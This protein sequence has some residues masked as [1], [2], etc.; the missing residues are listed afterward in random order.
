MWG[1]GVS[2]AAAD[3]VLDGTHR[4]RRRDRPRARPL[5]RARPQ[6]ARRRP[7]RPA[8]PADGPIPALAE[9]TDRKDGHDRTTWPATR[10]GDASVGD[11]EDWGLLDE[12]TGEP[13]Q[14]RRDPLGG[15]RPRSA[16]SGS[17]RR[18][19][20]AGC[21]RPTRSIQVLVDGR[22][23]VT[24]DGGEPTEIN[25]GDV[26]VFPRGWSG[27]LGH[28]RAVRKVYVDLLSI[29][30]Q[31]STGPE[32]G[33]DHVQGKAVAEARLAIA[34]TAMR[35]GGATVGERD[36]WRRRVVATQE[37]PAGERRPGWLAVG[38]SRR[39]Q[40]AE[41]AGPWGGR[42]RAADPGRPVAGRPAS[43]SARCA[44]P[45]SFSAPGA[46]SGGGSCAC[47]RI[48]ASGPASWRCRCTV[49]RTAFGT[50]RTGPRRGRPCRAQPALVTMAGSRADPSGTG[51]QR[52][53]PMPCAPEPRRARQ[54][55]PHR[56]AGGRR[57]R[58]T[59]CTRVEVGTPSRWWTGLSKR[60]GYS[61]AARRQ[62]RPVR[63]VRGAGD[64][65]VRR[66]VTDGRE[67]E[68]PAAPA[69]G[70]RP[71]RRGRAGRVTAAG[72]A[73]RMWSTRSRA[74][75]ASDLRPAVRLSDRPSRARRPRR[76]RAR[77]PRRRRPGR[78]S[79]G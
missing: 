36:G 67:H 70:R 53:A 78:R 71:V 59:A 47:L 13:M 55:E 76:P 33:M 62:L 69:H 57:W 42:S 48:S 56:R 19:R 10:P 1:P 60:C 75:L 15:R 66:W 46:P 28:P 4:R 40:I 37:P 73:G 27:H 52:A 8:V 65:H 6:P 41:V 31:W 49:V 51:R 43:A 18:A 5:R 39:R 25:A 45:R 64:G 21:S 23:T 16:G 30:V 44:V 9:L 61:S 3:L 12:A 63:R 58:V 24:P 38:R 29:P 11:L 79:A 22:M 34:C 77:R 26:A 7:D 2:R 17:A 14:T 72:A 32:P 20:R 74:G 54:A 68:Q 35:R 50:R